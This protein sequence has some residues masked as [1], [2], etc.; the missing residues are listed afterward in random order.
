MTPRI[1]A[2]KTPIEAVEC[3]I[4]F[5]L[6]RGARSKEAAFPRSPITLSQ[7]PAVKCVPNLVKVRRN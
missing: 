4:I 5:S 7:D 3:K 1:S 6:K 2:I